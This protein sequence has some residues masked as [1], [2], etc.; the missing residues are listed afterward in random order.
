VH[1]NI[2]NLVINSDFNCLSV[3]QYAVQVLKVEHIICCGHYGCG[4][5]IASTKDK[6]HGLVD[7]WIRHIKDIYDFHENDLKDL[8]EDTKINKLVEYNVMW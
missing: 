6:P 8:D 3:I 7:N 5:V 4:G 1:R 2:A